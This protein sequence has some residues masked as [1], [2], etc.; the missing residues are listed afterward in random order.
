MSHLHLKLKCLNRSVYTV[1]TN[2]KLKKTRWE[3]SKLK[4]TKCTTY[5]K[6]IRLGGSLV[7]LKIFLGWN[8]IFIMTHSLSKLASYT[9]KKLILN[10]IKYLSCPWSSMI[11]QENPRTASNI[12]AKITRAM[13]QL[14]TLWDMHQR[15][16]RTL[17]ICQQMLRHCYETVSPCLMF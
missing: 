6:Y 15:F 1:S 12:C 11:G 13:S 3:W 17:I 9:S 16:T 8:A 2:S 4:Y 7:T 14:L 10:W 5:Y